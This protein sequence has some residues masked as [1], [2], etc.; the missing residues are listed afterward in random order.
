MIK[1]ERWR[2]NEN[3]PRPISLGHIFKIQ[4]IVGT[5]RSFFIQNTILPEVTHSVVE[6]QF[7]KN[8]RDQFCL[9]KFDMESGDLL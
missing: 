4:S 5:K 8:M 1:C 6:L 9:S 2:N 7:K 3:L